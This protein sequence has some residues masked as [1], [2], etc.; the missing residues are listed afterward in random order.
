MIDPDLYRRRNT[1]INGEQYYELILVY[2]DD[3][4]FISENPK[5]IIEQIGEYYELKNGAEESS[6]FLGANIEKF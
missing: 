1:K 5:K 4:L 2:V 3:C 6:I